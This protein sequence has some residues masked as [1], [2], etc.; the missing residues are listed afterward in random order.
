MGAQ[1]LIKCFSM[2]LL[3][4]RTGLV[5]H[6]PSVASAGTR[7]VTLIWSSFVSVSSSKEGCSLEFEGSKE[8]KA[9][10]ETQAV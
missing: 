10:Y 4:Q 2:V 3:S 1:A 7:I 5:T 8:N 9:L 6:E